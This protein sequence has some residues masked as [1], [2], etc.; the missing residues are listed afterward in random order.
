MMRPNQ[1]NTGMSALVTLGNLNVSGSFQTQAWLTGPSPEIDLIGSSGNAISTSGNP[2][3]NQFGSGAG[4]TGTL[5]PGK[6]TIHLKFAITNWSYIPGSPHQIITE[7]G[8]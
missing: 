6:Y 8:E 7:L 2:P 1:G 3:S 4:P 5:S